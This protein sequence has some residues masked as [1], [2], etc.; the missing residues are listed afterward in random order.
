MRTVYLEGTS[1]MSN[2]KKKNLKCI[3][4]ELACFHLKEA[5]VHVN[6]DFTSRM[7]IIMFIVAKIRN[8]FNVQQCGFFFHVVLGRTLPL[9]CFL[10]QSWNCFKNN[11][12]Y[13]QK[14]HAFN[15]SAEVLFCRQQNSCSS[16]GLD[17]S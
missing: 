11:S 6:K 15:I 14:C 4:C 13:N 9:S 2:K 7:L 12:S 1:V 3:A 17:F 5:N 16:L 8:K 10:P